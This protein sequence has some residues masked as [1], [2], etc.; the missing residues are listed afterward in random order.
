MTVLIVTSSEILAEWCRKEL[1]GRF[2]IRIVAPGSMPSLSKYEKSG[3]CIFIDYESVDEQQIQVLID[4]CPSGTRFL[5]LS[6]TPCSE[7]L[8]KCP[9]LRGIPVYGKFTDTLKRDIA[10]SAR[11]YKIPGLASYGAFLEKIRTVSQC[12]SDILLLGESGS[13]KGWTARQIHRLSSK[14]DRVY[15]EQNVAELAPGI[16]EST[17]FGTERGA[18]TESVSKPGLF[19][20]ADGGTLF[21]DEI[22]E[23]N[24]RL[25]AKL[26]SVVENRFCRRLGGTKDIVFDERLIFATNKDLETC[27]KKH[28]FRKDLYY[29]INAITLKVPPLRMHPADIPRLAVKFASS[30]GKTISSGALAKLS[31]YAWPGNIREL[32]NIV[33]RSCVFARHSVI[34]A[35]DISFSGSV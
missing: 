24:C 1:G 30:H 18:Y 20:Q 16:I 27:V 33:M 32:E 11:R 5:I 23:L 13:G 29:R 12:S 26:L 34:G 28:S 31:S 9:F 35:E 2:G 4:G 15:I 19:E 7:V 21:L 25:Q 10:Y 6:D 22:G 14:Y 17:L 8:A 3:V